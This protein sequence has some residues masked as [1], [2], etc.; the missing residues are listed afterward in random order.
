MGRK[1]RKKI[2]D[3]MNPEKLDW[4]EK[5]EYSKLLAQFSKDAEA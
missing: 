2:S 1:V 3:M 5:N 4:H